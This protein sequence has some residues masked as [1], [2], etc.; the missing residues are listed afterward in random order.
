MLFECYNVSRVKPLQ[1]EKASENIITQ[2]R[3][4]I[5]SGKI[6]PGDRLASEKELLNQFSVSKA[7]MREA[8]RVLESMGL[9]EIKKGLD[10]G[11]FIAEAVIAV[12]E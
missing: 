4:A 9:I 2:I 10:A 3:D 8:L 12:M 1:T 5:L 6:K 7:T 11:V